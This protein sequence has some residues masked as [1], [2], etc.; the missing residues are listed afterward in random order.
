MSSDNGLRY[1]YFRFPKH[2]FDNM[3]MIKMQRHPAGFEYL[4]ILLKLYALSVENE[5]Y[6]E[7]PI[8]NGRADFATIAKAMRF[9]QQYTV[10]DA[11]HYFLKENIIEIFKADKVNENQFMLYMSQLNNLIG[12]SSREADRKR[13]ERKEKKA[14]MLEGKELKNKKE[15]GV[16]N[17]IFLTE[18]EYRELLNKYTNADE[19]IQRV[20]LYKAQYNAEYADD[21]AAVLKFGLKDGILKEE[22]NKKENESIKNKIK[23]WEREA[24]LGFEPPEE[25][26]KIIGEKEYKRLKKLANE[27]DE[28]R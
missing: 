6:I 27:S 2:F 16:C 21:Y 10:E 9:H 8:V 7:I 26:E 13:L 19:L 11:I 18:G 25:A 17:N 5:G 22:E 4:V 20:S 1:W 12:K 3:E 15:Y 23:Q 14:L 24:A 28:K